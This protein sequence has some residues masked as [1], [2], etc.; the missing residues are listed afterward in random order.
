M[1]RQCH[2]FCTTPNLSRPDSLS[3][4]LG[5]ISCCSP[6]PLF[7]ALGLVESKFLAVVAL[8]RTTRSA[9]PPTQTGL[10]RCLSVLVGILVAPR[11]PFSVRPWPCVEITHRHCAVVPHPF[12]SLDQVL[13]FWCVLF[14]SC[15]Q[16]LTDTCRPSLGPWPCGRQIF[17]DVACHCPTRSQA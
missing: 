9:W 12:W 5:W 4:C 2:S 7:V 6:L 16:H 17:A 10:T 1:L 3:V 14:Y 11:Y 15:A 13:I 8:C